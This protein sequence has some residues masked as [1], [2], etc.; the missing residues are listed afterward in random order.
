[1]NLPAKLEIGTDPAHKFKVT[2]EEALA[3]C[4]RRLAFPARL[5]DLETAVLSRSIA[6]I[7]RIFNDVSTLLEFDVE[8]FTPEKCHIFSEAIRAKGLI[9][10]TSY[11]KKLMK[12]DTNQYWNCSVIIVVGAPVTNCIGFIEGTVR[13]IACPIRHQRET[14]NGHKVQRKTTDDQEK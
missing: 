12:E 7:S 8:Q 11:S 3:I 6:S 1:M 14:Y 10:I 13:P 5:C 2:A 9:F 4:M